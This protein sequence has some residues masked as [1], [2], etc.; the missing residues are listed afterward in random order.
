MRSLIRVG[1]KAMRPS[2]TRRLGTI[3]ALATTAAV[4]F[5]AAASAGPPFRETIHEEFEFVDTN[6]CDAGL[7]VEV[8]V[9]LDIRVHANPHGRDRLVYFMQHATETDVFTNLANGK[10]VTSFAK[11]IE[12][13]QRVTIELLI[14]HGGT[15]NDPSDDVV[16]S[17]ELVKGSTGRSDDFCEAAVPALS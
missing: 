8:A 15:P 5:A 16:L 10:S 11:V 17:E 3:L 6:F 1:R 13:D 14:D 7:T 2:R 9:V 4:V 12:K